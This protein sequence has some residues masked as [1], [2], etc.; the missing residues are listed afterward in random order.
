MSFGGPPP[1]FSVLFTIVPILIIGAI[2]FTLGRGI[3]T[4]MSNN[5]SDRVTASGRIVSKRTLVSGGGGDTSAHTS[6][7]VTFELENG[8]RQEF[9]V[10]AAEF[11]LMVEGDHGQLSYQGTRFLDFVRIQPTARP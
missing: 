6:Y 7:Y 9:H 2:V 11:G 10:R 3:Y 5:A 1:L 4:W 8:M